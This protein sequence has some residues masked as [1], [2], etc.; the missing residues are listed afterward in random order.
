MI[1]FIHISEMFNDHWKN[2]T[3]IHFV[4]TV[5]MDKKEPNNTQVTWVAISLITQRTMEPAQP[6]YLLSKYFAAVSFL[7]W[8][9]NN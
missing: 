4:Y 5:C 8:V 9:H 6:H 7:P 1:E 2:V 3:C